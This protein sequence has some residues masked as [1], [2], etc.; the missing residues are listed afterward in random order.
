[1][2]L[3][4]KRCWGNKGCSRL[5]CIMKIRSST[6]PWEKTVI[7]MRSEL[8][9]ECWY[10]TQDVPWCMPFLHTPSLHSCQNVPH[11][12]PSTPPHGVEPIWI[13][14]EV[15]DVPFRTN[16]LGLLWLSSYQECLANQLQLIISQPL[17][18]GENVSKI[19]S[20]GG[21]HSCPQDEVRGWNSV[22]TP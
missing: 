7:G 4:G 5:N 8:S 21:L 17:A 16:R 14:Q 13:L 3:L 19:L 1:M 20:N 11:S 2:C 12:F 15:C 10:E 9:L 22:T 6:R 18:W